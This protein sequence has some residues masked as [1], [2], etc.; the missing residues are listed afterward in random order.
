ML[1]AE[2]AYQGW[3]LFDT[4]LGRNDRGVRRDCAVSLGLR[5]EARLSIT[6]LPVSL[7]LWLIE[8]GYCIRVT[9]IVMSKSRYRSS[10]IP[11]IVSV[12]P[13]ESSEP[14]TT[15]PIASSSATSSDP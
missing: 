15:V 14:L 9:S 4:R 7:R 1:D 2:A 6:G 3:N 10:V 5:K 12:P 11:I 13:V 8:T